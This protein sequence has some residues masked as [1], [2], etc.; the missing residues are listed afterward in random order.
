MGKKLIPQL[1]KNLILNLFKVIIINTY[2]KTK[3]KVYGDNVNTNF[4]GKKVPKENASYESLSLVMLDSVA[5]VNKYHY[6]Q[7]VLE[8]CK[9]EIKKTKMENFINNDLDRS[10][11]DESDNE[12]DRD[13]DSDSDNESDNNEYEKSDNDSDNEMGNDVSNE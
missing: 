4:Q 12:T 8:E 2:I 9:Y 7:T 11:S 1:A 13:S 6:P 3:I 10:V 5:K